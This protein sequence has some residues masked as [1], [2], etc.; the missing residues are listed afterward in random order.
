MMKLLTIDLKD[1]LHRAFKEKCA[2]EGVTMSE[3]IRKLIKE[4]LEKSK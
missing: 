3:V 1:D 2:R 4:W